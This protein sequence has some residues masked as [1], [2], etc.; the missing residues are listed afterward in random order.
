MKNKFA[1]FFFFNL[2][3][4]LPDM[5]FSIFLNCFLFY[6]FIGTKIKYIRLKMRKIDKQIYELPIKKK[7][8]KKK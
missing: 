5:N 2:V 6:K 1:T 8:K 7:E 4:L 3:L